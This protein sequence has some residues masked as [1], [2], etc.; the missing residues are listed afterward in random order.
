M[1]HYCTS[2]GNILL[3]N[4]VLSFMWK[5]LCHVTT[6]FNNQ[7]TEDKVHYF[8]ETVFYNG[9]GIL[10]QDNGPIYIALFVQELFPGHEQNFSVISWLDLSPIALLWDALE[11]KV[12]IFFYLLHTKTLKIRSITPFALKV[13]SF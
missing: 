7:Q 8:Q 12:P 9:I 3:G 6:Y 10:Q 5:I 2:L 1:V 11:N 13:A 4:I